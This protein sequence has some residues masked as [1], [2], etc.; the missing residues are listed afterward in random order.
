M[1]TDEADA[2]MWRMVMERKPLL[3][4]GTVLG[5]ELQR[6]GS[7]LQVL[8]THL[9]ES[10]PPYAEVVFRLDKEHIALL[11]ASKI[12]ELLTE[13]AKVTRRF[14]ELSNKLDPLGV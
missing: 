11:D 5:E 10:L 8:G 6:V 14:K 2:I 4:R 3:Q 13:A 7:A 12:T 1:S 9:T